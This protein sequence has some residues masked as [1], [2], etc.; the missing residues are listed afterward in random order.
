MTAI[1][2]PLL[3]V[4]LLLLCQPSMAAEIAPPPQMDIEAIRQKAE[5]GQA[6]FQAYLG[7][8]YLNG[9]G[10]LEQDN[11][12]AF[13]WYRRAAEQGYP[14]A[15][16]NLGILYDEG[17]GV[18]QNHVAGFFWLSIAAAAAP[19]KRD[20]DERRDRAGDFLTLTQTEEI[21]ERAR[22]WKP[23]NRPGQETASA[24]A[25]PV[26]VTPGIPTPWFQLPPP[27]QKTVNDNVQSGWMIGKIEKAVEDGMLIYRAQVNKPG[28]ASNLIR[29]DGAG[30]LVSVSKVSP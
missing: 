4:A 6:A 12:E 15:E 5:Q 20:Y 1:V 8:L 3:F 22:T 16:Y 26:K 17:L 28:S 9:K 14:A 25:P 7:F 23:G 11:A 18:E 30:H 10:G 13:R 29:V 19:D 27:V 24:A 2:R 21:T